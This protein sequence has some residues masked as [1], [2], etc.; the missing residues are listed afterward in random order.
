MLLSNASHRVG[1]GA[2]VMNDKGEVLIVL[3]RNGRFKGT[4]VWKLPL[5]RVRICTAAIREV[6]EETGIDTEFVEILSFSG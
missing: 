1:I 5:M 2:F 3:E 6:K 4:N